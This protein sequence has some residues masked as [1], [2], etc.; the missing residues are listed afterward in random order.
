MV[1]VPGGAPEPWGCGTDGHSQWVRWGGLGLD[2]TILKI[3]SNPN[4]S[5]ILFYDSV[6][7]WCLTKRT[8]VHRARDSATPTSLSLV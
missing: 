5:T 4:G 3:F 1:A 7:P 2:R 6:W 8:K